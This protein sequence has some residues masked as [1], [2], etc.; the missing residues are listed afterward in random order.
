ME[1]EF[2]SDIDSIIRNKELKNKKKFFVIS[3]CIVISLSLWL[4]IKFSDEYKYPIQIPITITNLPTDKVL[5]NNDTILLTINMKSQGIN[6]LYYYFFA[7]KK[8]INI[9]YSSL[10]AKEDA[11]KTNESFATLQLIKILDKHL[12]FKHEIINVSPENINLNFEKTYLKI[13]PLKLNLQL[14]FEDQFLLYDTVKAYPNKIC[15]SGTEKTLKKITYLETEP[16]VLNNLNSNQNIFATIKKPEKDTDLRLFANKTKVS[17][18][19]EKFTESTIEIPV[20]ISN[21]NSNKKLKL[22]PDVVKITYLV[23]LK[24]YKKINNELFGAVV[25][26]NINKSEENNKLKVELVKFPSYIKITKVYPDN[27]EYIIFK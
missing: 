17:I 3:I 6:A 20:S 14:N 5:I 4:L 26:G 10:K 12:L 18:S 11:K 19:V 15:I 13:V 8:V 16:I 1:T 7:Q 24:D 23:A 2:K 27:V 21:N 25:N 9:D 22:F